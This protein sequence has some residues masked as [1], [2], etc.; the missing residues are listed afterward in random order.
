MWAR[1][2]PV[3]PTLEH[4]FWVVVLVLTV[5]GLRIYKPALKAA[6]LPTRIAPYTVIL[7]DYRLQA[8]LRT[9]GEKFIYAV[10]SD[11]SRVIEVV[12]RQRLLDFASGKTQAVIESS[13]RKTTTFD[14]DLAQDTPWLPDPSKQCAIPGLDTQSVL[15]QEVVNGYRTVKVSNGPTTQ[16]YALDYGCALIKDRADWLDG[17]ASEKILVALIAGEPSP[18]LFEDP[19]GYREVPPSQAAPSVPAMQAMDAYYY[20]HRPP[21]D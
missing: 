6:F 9:P 19:A 20:N 14:A 2:F 16:W 10:R 8:D 18:L 17:Q 1:N 11:G 15:G 12:G 4:V 3:K 7:Q 13:R 21:E 5:N